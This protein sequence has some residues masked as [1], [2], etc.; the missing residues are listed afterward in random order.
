MTAQ[1][2]DDLSE[3]ETDWIRSCHLFFRPPNGVIFTRGTKL[4]R[5]GGSEWRIV[6]LVVSVLSHSLTLSPNLHR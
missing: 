1:R 2:G 3:D 4:S 5:D 6:L